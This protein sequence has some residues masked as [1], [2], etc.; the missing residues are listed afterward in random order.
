M[1]TGTWGA[2][3]A[4]AAAVLVAACSAFP[5][6]V[7]G[8]AAPG[9]D[10]WEAVRATC[11]TRPKQP[12]PR[13]HGFSSHE[14]PGALGFHKPRTDE[15]WIRHPWVGPGTGDV[16]QACVLAHEMA[17]YAGVTGEADATACA[18][19]ALARLSGVP[20]AAVR[21]GRGTASRPRAGMGSSVKA[22][23]PVASWLNAAGV[24]VIR[25]KGQRVKALRKY[26]SEHV[27][28]DLADAHLLGAT[29]SIGPLRLEPLHLPSAEH[30]ALQRL[31]KQRHRYQQL[32]CA[33][34]RRLLDLIRWS[35]PALEAALPDIFTQ[36]ALAMLHDL[37]EP[38]RLLALRR[39]QLRRFLGRHASGSGSENATRLMPLQGLG[40][41][42]PRLLCLRPAAASP[43]AKSIGPACN[44]LK[45]ASPIH[46]GSSPSPAD[47]VAGGTS[48]RSHTYDAQGATDR[49]RR[50]RPRSFSI[51]NRGS[52]ANA[53]LERPP[54]FE[55]GAGAAWR[56][57]RHARNLLLT[58]SLFRK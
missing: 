21:C 39:D 22:W 7:P 50:Q 48:M 55:P 45:S 42:V 17:H 31:T 16:T 34:K 38:E 54:Q 25:M 37:F 46:P 9:A 51:A 57:H 53:R 2:A 14:L 58:D 41:D 40:A 19:A 23:F 12:A 35:C 6:P 15:V 36:L 10:I 13:I 33:S 1:H 43:L 44:A 52:A 11:G 49:H 4:L 20:V 32:R 56:Q 5:P 29:P 28:T 47:V 18:R 3:P 26:L 30:H 24:E 27:K 8:R